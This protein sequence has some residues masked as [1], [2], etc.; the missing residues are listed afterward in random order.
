V[1]VLRPVRLVG[2]D[3]NVIPRAVA[4]PACQIVTGFV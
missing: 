3:D 2:N 4:A 1:N